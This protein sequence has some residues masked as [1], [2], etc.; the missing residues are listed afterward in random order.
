MQSVKIKGGTDI[1]GLIALKHDTEAKG[2]YIGFASS[3]PHNSPFSKDKKYLG[4][5]GHLFAIAAEE[6]LNK[7]NGDM[8][9]FAANEKLA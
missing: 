4:V 8:Y 3:A 2:I 5:G 6:A 1:E 7:T 9:A